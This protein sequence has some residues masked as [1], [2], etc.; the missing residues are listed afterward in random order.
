M[1]NVRIHEEDFV[2]T[3]LETFPLDFTVKAKGKWRGL[4]LRNIVYVIPLLDNR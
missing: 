4:D 2:L 1:I 3:I